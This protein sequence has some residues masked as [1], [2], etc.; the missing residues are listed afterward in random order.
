MINFGQLDVLVKRPAGRSRGGRNG[1]RL[2][3]A[4]GGT[5]L[6]CPTAGAGWPVLAGAAWL[7]WNAI[8]SLFTRYM[9]EGWRRERDRSHEE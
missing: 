1:E 9:E 4:Q 2:G 3:N 6:E 7:R 5:R 8:P